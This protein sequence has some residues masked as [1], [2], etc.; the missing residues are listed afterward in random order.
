MSYCFDLELYLVLHSKK[1]KARCTTWAEVGLI[2]YVLLLVV[3]VG[4]KIWGIIQWT[5]GGGQEH[6]TRP[7]THT[8]V[9]IDE[10]TIC[11]IGLQLPCPGQSASSGASGSKRNQIVRSTIEGEEYGTTLTSRCRFSST[12]WYLPCGWL[13]HFEIGRAWAHHL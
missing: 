4:W 9:T 6:R 12:L 5:W 7:H 3:L 13:E 10:P 11:C 1:K 2:W 8:P